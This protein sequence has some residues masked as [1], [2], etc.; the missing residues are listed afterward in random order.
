[1]GRYQLLE[2]GRQAYVSWGRSQPDQNRYTGEICRKNGDIAVFLGTEEDKD[3]F[4]HIMGGEIPEDVTAIDLDEQAFVRD[5]DFEYH[6]EF[7]D[8][9]N[10]DDEKSSKKSNQFDR[11]A[12]SV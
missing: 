5:T 11:Y 7:F 3:Y 12:L 2:D 4:M 9:N 10:E 6:D 8:D 1:M